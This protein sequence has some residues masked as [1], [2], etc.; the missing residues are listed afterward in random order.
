MIPG[1]RRLTDA[2]HEYDVRIGCQIAHAGR[3]TTR[4]YVEGLA[5]EAPSAIPEHVLGEVPEEMSVELIREVQGSF[6][7]AAIRAR[8]A[9]FD[10]VE[11]HGA[12]GYLFHTFVSPLSNRRDDD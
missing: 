7:A 4:H 5:P 10:L 1:L 11:L 6:A 9:N 8:E 2:V 12:H 3:Q